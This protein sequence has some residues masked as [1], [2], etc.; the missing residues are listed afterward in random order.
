MERFAMELKVWRDGRADPL[1]EGLEQLAG[2]LE[3][4][5]LESGTLMIF[6]R[7]KAAPPL[8]ERLARRTIEHAGQRIDL[9]RL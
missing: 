1:A 6:D 8:P 2:Y 9:L 5:G 7:R 3:R 4:L